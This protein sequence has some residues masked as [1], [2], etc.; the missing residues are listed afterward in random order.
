MKRRADVRQAILRLP[1]PYRESIVMADIAGFSY[2]EMAEIL[3]VPM[4]TVM[5]L[6]FRARRILRTSLR[7]G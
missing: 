6:L 3:G 7:E 4:R 5:S 2:R 1:S